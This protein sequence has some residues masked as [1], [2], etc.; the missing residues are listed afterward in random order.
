M[1]RPNIMLRYI[2]AAMT[3]LRGVHVYC[4]DSTSNPDTSSGV[5]GQATEKAIETAKTRRWRN[6]A[7]AIGVVAF[8]II[9]VIAA[10]SNKKDQ[11]HCDP[12]PA[13]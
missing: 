12:T 4:D 13:G 8:G 2:I 11:G 10:G 6:T 9:A 7:I 1:F 3:L 5:I